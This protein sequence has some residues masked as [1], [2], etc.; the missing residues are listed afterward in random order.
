MNIFKLLKGA[1]FDYDQ[2]KEEN[3]LSGTDIFNFFVSDHLK[4]NTRLNTKKLRKLDVDAFR[5]EGER[6][7]S[8]FA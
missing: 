4:L 1:K 2:I 8:K 3:M 7:K 6:F 5:E